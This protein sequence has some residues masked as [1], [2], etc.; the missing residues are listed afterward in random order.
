MSGEQRQ[1]MVA[2]IKKSSEDA[3]VACRNIRRDA[4]KHFETAEK[5]KEMTEDERD[6]GKEQ[7][8]KLLKTFED[9]ITDMA[10][11]KAKEIMEQ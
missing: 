11:K 3:K 7:V 9:K 1:K 10:D 4:N 2:R 6:Q 5:N 8:Q